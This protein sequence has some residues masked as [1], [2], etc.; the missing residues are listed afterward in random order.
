MKTTNYE[1]SKKLKEAGFEGKPEFYFAVEGN[2]R[3]VPYE[4]LHK[5]SFLDYDL[6]LLLPSYD[7][8]TILEVLPAFIGNK[9]CLV[10][11]VAFDEIHYEGDSENDALFITTTRENES[12]ADTAGRLWL[13]LKE[14]DLV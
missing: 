1:I 2:L 9:N 10:I 8:E 4:V 3:P 7:L 12:L 11:D 6:N 5:T 14:K 13:K